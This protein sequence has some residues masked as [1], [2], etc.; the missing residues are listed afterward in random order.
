VTAIALLFFF[1]SSDE[2]LLQWMNTRAQQQLTQRAQK[3]AAVQGRAAAE[4]HK[5]AVRKKILELIG[6]LPEQRSPLQA[7]TFKTSD[8]GKF[9]VE[10]VTFESFP[11]YIVTA[12]MYRP[13]ASGRHPAVLISMGH[14]DSG[15]ASAQRI[16]ANLALKG[17]VVLAF[18]PMGQGERQQAFDPRLG[19]SIIGGGTDQHFAAGAQA[20][21][22]GQTFARYRVWDGIRALD[23]LAT[24]PEVDMERIGCTGCSG[25]GTIATYISAL[26][27]RVKVAAPAC[28][29]NSFRTL[30]TGPVGDSEQSL[31]G[32]LAAGLDQTDYVQLFSPK[33]WYLASTEGDY[34][35]PAGARQVYDEARDWYARIYDQPDKVRW[36]VGPG[37]HGTPLLVREGLYDWMIRWLMDG[38]GNTKEEVVDLIPDP[39][40]W[41]TEKG[42]V[43]GRDLYEIINEIPRQ[44]GSTAELKTFVGNLLKNNPSFGANITLQNEGRGAKKAII[45]VDAPATDIEK[46][47]NDNYLIVSVEPARSQKG[48]GTVPGNWLAN[49]RAWLIG[50][51]LPA[52]HASEIRR[53][54]DLAIKAGA[55]P[56][57]ISAK[58]Y[59]VSGL[60]LLLA[61]AAD[62]RIGKVFLERTPFSIDAALKSPVH[63]NLHDAVIPGF[64]LRWDL[65]DLVA[66][67]KPRPVEWT[68][69][70]DWMGNLKVLDGP[71]KYTSSD[72]NH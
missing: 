16:A 46:W 1:A 30:F 69:P 29:M 27:D 26:D 49:T 11:N 44:K 4:A 5:Q 13:K 65:N 41:A 45:V 20:I 3:I 35:T 18:D 72:P 47:K 68:N 59:G 34:F 14:W 71:Y 37:G 12:N 58:A 23:Y 60:W 33:P 21:L 56:A 25:G 8:R 70:T 50:Q 10:N 57:Q 62:E 66:L 31:P 36:V 42:Q 9:I 15:K 55:D 19:R 54:V 6:G 43:G 53:G 24:R 40:L 38:K 32:F 28:Y 2:T 64:S 67:V 51:N 63:R 17:F 39:Q 48:V 61:A 22:L 52:L 7:R